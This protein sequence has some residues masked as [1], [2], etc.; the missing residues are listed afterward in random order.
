MSFENNTRAIISVDTVEQP[1]A[2]DFS[3]HC[4]VIGSYTHLERNAELQ[5]DSNH[6]LGCSP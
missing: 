4:S 5:F 3:N 2:V 6:T 1:L